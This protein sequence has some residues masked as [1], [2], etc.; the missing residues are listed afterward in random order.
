MVTVLCSSHFEALHFRLIMLINHPITFLPCIEKMMWMKVD[1][2]DDTSPSPS[3]SW[4]SDSV[5]TLIYTGRQH[6]DYTEGRDISPSPSSPWDFAANEDET[7]FTK[8]QEE[9]IRKLSTQKLWC[10]LTKAV[11]RWTLLLPLLV[12]LLFE[13]S[14]AAT[15]FMDTTLFMFQRVCYMYGIPLIQLQTWTTKKEW[16]GGTYFDRTCV[17]S[18]QTAYN[19]SEVVAHLVDKEVFSRNINWHGAQILPRLI[20]EETASELRAFVLQKNRENVDMIED[21]LENESRFS[22]ALQVDQHPSVAKAMKELLSNE[23]LLDAF[24]ATFGDRDPVVLE[25]VVLTSVYGAKAQEWHP[26]VPGDTSATKYGLHYFDYYSMFIPLQ[27]TTEA[28]GATQICPGTHMCNTMELPYAT[29][30]SCFPVIDDQ[31]MWETGWG[32]MYNSRLTHRGAAHVDQANGTERVLLIPSFAP[33]PTSSLHRRVE[34]RSIPRGGVYAM[35]WTQWGYTVSDFQYSDSRMKYPWRILH[36]FGLEWPKYYRGWN[37]WDIL[38]GR[39]LDEDTEDT[40]E[41]WTAHLEKTFPWLSSFI[42]PAGFEQDDDEEEDSDYQMLLDFSMASIQQSRHIFNRVQFLLLVVFMNLVSIFGRHSLA[43][44]SIVRLFTVKVVVAVIIAAILN[45]VANSCWANNISTGRS[46]NLPE[47]TSQ[48]PQLA[49]TLPNKKDVLVTTFL[50]SRSLGGYSNM[51][52]DSNPGNRYWLDEIVSHYASG[53]SNLTTELKRQLCNDVAGLIGHERRRILSRNHMGNWG[54]INE[55]ETHRYC[56]KSLFVESKRLTKPIVNEIDILWAQTKFDYFRDTVLHRRILPEYLVALQNRILQ[57]KFH[58]DTESHAKPD[59]PMLSRV[60]TFLPLLPSKIR[61]NERKRNGSF[62][63][64]RTVPVEL[65][66]G[67]WLLEG[68]LVD[69]WIKANK[70]VACTL[71]IDL[72]FLFPFFLA[73]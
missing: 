42:V 17:I 66:D 27:N 62:F 70:D 25:L 51:I 15:F 8:R 50:K 63:D 48:F 43:A 16:S 26:D 20:S 31:G 69:V 47:Y 60:L 22:F 7:P 9:I 57:Y 44:R 18:D 14:I 1:R 68:D 13:I 35:H 73:C 39:I 29:H 6:D 11:R 61:E 38:I 58:S 2:Y 21:I 45:A 65:V 32:V 46:S 34:T 10:K 49:A 36:S 41:S 67:A 5:D 33:R 71:L 40:V 19:T 59:K 56:H 52:D 30:E 3:S 4:E 12:I 28:M 24:E 54:V 23:M 64:M 53:F 55:A 72:F 37:Y